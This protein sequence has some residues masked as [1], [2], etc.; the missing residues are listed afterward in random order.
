MD[1]TLAIIGTAGRKD[2]AQ[3]LTKYHFEAMCEC[4]RLLLQQ[5]SESDYGVDSL[6]SGGQHGLTMSPSDCI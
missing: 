1:S 4:A 3:R 5:F 6:V 2:D